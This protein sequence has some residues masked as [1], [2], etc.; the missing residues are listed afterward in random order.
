LALDEPK[1]TDQVFTIN[2]LKY[3]IDQKLMEEAK[4]INIDYVDTPMQ[5]GLFLTSGNSL[6]GESS[7]GSSCSC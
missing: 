1:E 6:G 2:E 3:V 7:C 5:Q 4:D